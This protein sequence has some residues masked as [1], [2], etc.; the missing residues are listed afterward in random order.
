MK[1]DIEL[2]FEI[3]ALRNLPRAWRHFFNPDVQSINEHIF[4]VVWIALTPA[5][6][7]KLKS[8][9][10]VLKMALVHDLTEILT[11]DVHHLSRQYVKR[12]EKLAVDDIF[13]Q[14]VHYREMISL[15]EEY[16]ERKTIEAKIVKDADNLDIQL[17]LREQAARGHSVGTIWNASRDKAVYRKL[18]TQSAKILWRKIARANPHDWHDKSPRNRF[19]GGDWKV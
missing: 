7:E 9:E 18:F 14:T 5:R 17:E 1:R 6:Y 10:K 2:L 15:Y 8:H 12:N 4:R 19:K 11:G 13:T 16:E 3:G